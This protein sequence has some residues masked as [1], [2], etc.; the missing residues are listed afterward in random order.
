MGLGHCGGLLV[1]AGNQVL[2]H[3]GGVLLVPLYLPFPRGGRD[4]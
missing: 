3:Q 4:P 2:T 1:A